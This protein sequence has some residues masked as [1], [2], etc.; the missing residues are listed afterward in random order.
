V[1]AVVADGAWSARDEDLVMFHRVQN[2]VWLKEQQWVM[3]A[4]C[5]GHRLAD[6][7]GLG[8]LMQQVMLLVQAAGLAV[9][10]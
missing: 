1:S 6:L 8:G 4:F 3:H 9:E 7:E 10:E 2:L 5:H